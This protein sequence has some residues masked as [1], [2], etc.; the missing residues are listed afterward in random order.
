MLAQHLSLCTMVLFL[1][2][3]SKSSAAFWRKAQTPWTELVTS[4][5][6]SIAPYCH[7]GADICFKLCSCELSLCQKPALRCQPKY[8]RKSIV[9]ERCDS[10]NISKADCAGVQ[11]DFALHWCTLFHIASRS[12]HVACLKIS[13]SL[14]RSFHVACLRIM[15]HHNQL[16]AVLLCVSHCQQAAQLATGCRLLV[17]LP[18]AS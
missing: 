16:K 13:R 6:V 2:A 8:Q 14:S 12:F 3:S 11:N 18:A 17:L 9:D 1:V 5:E 4:V 7:S 15:A 10:S